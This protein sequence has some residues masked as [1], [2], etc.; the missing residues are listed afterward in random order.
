MRTVSYERTLF[1]HELTDL[2]DW[3]A[4]NSKMVREKKND[5]GEIALLSKYKR[6]NDTRPILYCSEVYW[7][8]GPT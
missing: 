5:K 7:S 1:K 3:A 2:F 6:L 4:R 8:R